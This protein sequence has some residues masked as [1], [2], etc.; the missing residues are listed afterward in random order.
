MLSI[1]VFTI[2]QTSNVLFSDYVRQLTDLYFGEIQEGIQRVAITSIA[3]QP[4]IDVFAQ[5]I[6][7]VLT[8]STLIIAVIGLG[9]L[10]YHKK[11]DNKDY[12]MILVGAMFFPTLVVS[13]SS[14]TTIFWRAAPMVFIPLS[15]G[16][17][18]LS[19][20]RFRRPLIILFSIILILLSFSIVHKT[21]YDLQTFSFTQRDYQATRFIVDNS[22]TEP[23]ARVLAHYRVMTYLRP[24]T[25]SDQVVIYRSD[26]SDLME[27]VTEV[28]YIIYSVG[29]SKSFLSEGILPQESLDHLM[30][31]KYSLIHNSG[32]FSHIYYKP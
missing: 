22:F 17:S 27:G 31:N 23:R 16:V 5:I 28:N 25:L 10:W 9:L 32:S 12:S 29:M 18:Y 21:F 30:S 7:R 2:I 24:S 3:P 19:Q 13:F 11:L 20:E 1:I 4:G 8:I 14:Y 6:S 26:S 15:M